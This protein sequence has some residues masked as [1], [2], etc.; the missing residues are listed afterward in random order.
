MVTVADSRS[1]SSTSV[2]V[3]AASITLAASPS[4]K[5]RVPP[6]VMAGASLTAVTVTF[7]VPVRAAATP[8]LTEV[9]MVKFWS[10]SAAGVKVTPAS[11]VLTS[12]TAPLALQT[13]PAKV[14]VTAPEVAVERVPAAASERVR[15]AVRVSPLSGSVMTMSV[16]LKA[17]A[18]SVKLSAALRLVAVGAS[19]TAVMLNVMVFV[20]ESAPPSLTR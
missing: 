14:E 7:L 17:A 5:F 20:A 19:W 8:S 12:A 15:V 18:S 6:A 3:R 10:W 2:M 1:V 13:P 9:A 16:R 11:R 4:V